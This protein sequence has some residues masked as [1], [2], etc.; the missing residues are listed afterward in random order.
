MG[1]GHG[2]LPGFRGGNLP[3]GHYPNRQGGFHWHPGGWHEGWDAHPNWGGNQGGGVNPAVLAALTGGGQGQGQGGQPGQGGT[4]QGGNPYQPGGGGATQPGGGVTAA[5]ANGPWSSNPFLDTLVGAE[6]QGREGP[7]VR[8]DGGLAKGFFQFHDETWRQYAANVP[9]A[10]QYATAEGAPPEM[11]QAVAMT[12]PIYLWGQKTRDKLHAKFG[13]FNE[14]MTIGDLAKQFGG[15][16]GGTTR[17]AATPAPAPRP[18]IV[19]SQQND[20]GP[21]A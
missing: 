15:D 4:P 20:A 17:T 6:S 19:P 5:P 11:Q 10:S 21:I 2:P 7:N 18:P 14:N 1:G 12:A 13:A 9:G 8:G 16:G 3:A